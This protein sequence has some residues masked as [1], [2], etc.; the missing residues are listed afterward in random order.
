MRS[1]LVGMQ[2]GRNSRKVIEEMVDAGRGSQMVRRS[3]T[4]QTHPSPNLRGGLADK[5]PW[6]LGGRDHAD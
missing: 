1:W 3:A 6:A 2:G 5:G 4:H